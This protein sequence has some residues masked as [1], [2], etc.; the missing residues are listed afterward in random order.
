MKL[1]IVERWGMYQQGVVGIFETEG[2]A[3]IAM[4]EA[5]ADERDDY[6]NF[7]ITEL[8]LNARERIYRRL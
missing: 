3:E 5:K 2:L 1:Y 6:H 8:V 4:D 7:T